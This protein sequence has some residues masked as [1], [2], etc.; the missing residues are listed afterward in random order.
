MTHVRS[1]GEIRISTRCVL[2]LEVHI[3]ST[4]TKRNLKRLPVYWHYCIAVALIVTEVKYC[5][6]RAI[7]L[8]HGSF[9]GVK[10]FHVSDSE[11]N[12]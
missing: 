11:N 7:I 5:E 6:I 8:G 9:K 1:V 3:T 2:L 12:I 4:C 10:E